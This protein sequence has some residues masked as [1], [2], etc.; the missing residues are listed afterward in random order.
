MHFNS[1]TPVS[2]LNYYFRHFSSIF[3]F[4]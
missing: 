1:N 3:I 2:K 4:M